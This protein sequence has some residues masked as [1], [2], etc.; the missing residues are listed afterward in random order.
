MDD[1]HEGTRLAA[2]STANV[3]SK[4]TTWVFFCFH[5][6]C[7]YTILSWILLPKSSLRCLV[8]FFLVVY[9]LFSQ[10]VY[11]KSRMDFGCHVG[12]DGIDWKTYYGLNHKRSKIF[13]LKKC[14]FSSEGQINNYKMVCPQLC[15]QASDANQG[16]D[17]KEIVSAILPVLLDTGITN[18]VKEVRSVR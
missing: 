17:G 9:I 18:L 16:K 6:V 7:M 2:T 12:Q 14:F 8:S 5:Y 11:I 13:L 10:I 15:I 3:L 1:V 4:V